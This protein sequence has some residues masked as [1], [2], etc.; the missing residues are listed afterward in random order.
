[1]VES[2]WNY[3]QSN[4]PPQAPPILIDTEIFDQD[5]IQQ[6]DL[7][8]DLNLNKDREDDENM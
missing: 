8:A 6:T 7:L 1:M 4:Q 2:R 3:G 5:V